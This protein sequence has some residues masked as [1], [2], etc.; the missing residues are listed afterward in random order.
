MRVQQLILPKNLEVVSNTDTVTKKELLQK[1]DA[2]YIIKNKLITVAGQMF[3][4]NEKELENSNRTIKGYEDYSGDK[5][6]KNDILDKVRGD[7]MKEICSEKNK[8]Y[9]NKPI[10]GFI[11]I[12]NINKHELQSNKELVWK[13]ISINFSQ[14]F[15]VQG[16]KNLIV[17]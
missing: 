15:Y 3:M 12:L 1:F 10:K 6:V 9:R 14:S 17:L 4:E 5:K 13:K 7:N 2:K 16:I 8:I 11:K